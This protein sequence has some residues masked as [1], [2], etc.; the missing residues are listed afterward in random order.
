MEESQGRDRCSSI[1]FREF[2][3]V[4]A[5]PLHL[6]ELDVIISADAFYLGIRVRVHAIKHDSIFISIRWFDRKN[7][8][9][10]SRYT[11]YRICQV[12]RDRSDDIEQL[13][14]C[15][16]LFVIMVTECHAERYLTFSCQVKYGTHTFFGRLTINHITGEKH[17]IRFLCIQHFIDPFD[18]NGRLRIVMD[19]MYIGELYDLKFT[20]LVEFPWRLL[21]VAVQ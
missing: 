17:Q 9:A 11:F 21:G 4:I 10:G 3:T 8:I 6:V 16:A 18:R 7:I 2:G 13:C 1:L 14:A 20:V 12:V 19:I 5:I 15:Q